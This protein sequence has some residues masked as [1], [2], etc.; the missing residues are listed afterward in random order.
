MAAPARARLQPLTLTR[1][2]HAVP[3]GGNYRLIDI[4]ISNCINSGINKINALT[5]F[6]S[7][8]L[9]HHINLTYN[10]SSGLSGCFDGCRQY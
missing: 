10:L 4:P 8:S 2:K 9:N 5:Q 1:A 6:N 3:L 7:Q